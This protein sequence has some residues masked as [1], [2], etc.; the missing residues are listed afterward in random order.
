MNVGK[1]IR[2]NRIINSKSDK[3]F[4]ATI[5]H[6]FHRGVL[7]G[8]D[9]IAAAIQKIADGGPDVMTMHKGLAKKYFP[10]TPPIFVWPSRARPSH[11]TILT[12]MCR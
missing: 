9:N 12:W 6:G 10:P 4:F 1:E 8:I 3:V 2:M 5:D 11:P 7:P